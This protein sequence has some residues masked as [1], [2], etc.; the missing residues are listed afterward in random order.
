M[1]THYIWD[2]V[3]DS[4]LMETDENGN[5]T[6]EYITEPVPY[7]RVVSQRRSGVTS[8]YHYDGQGSTRQ[9]GR[10][11]HKSCSE[12]D[13]FKV[14]VVPAGQES[15]VLDPNFCCRFVL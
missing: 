11:H 1:T 5:I 9:S 3:S 7:G 2:T 14:V 4:Y 15:F 13:F 8:F 12:H 10:L 6:A